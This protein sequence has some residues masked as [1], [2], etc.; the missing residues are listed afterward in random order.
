[1]AR[2]QASRVELGFVVLEPAWD[3]WQVRVGAGEG[4]FRTDHQARVRGLLQGPWL[5]TSQ[6]DVTFLSPRRPPPHL[7]LFPYWNFVCNRAILQPGLSF[8]VFLVIRI[9]GGVEG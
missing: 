2:C 6:R 4:P 5:N 9:W 7:Q 8:K 1:M 3:P